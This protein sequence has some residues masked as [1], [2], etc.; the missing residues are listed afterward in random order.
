MGY[1]FDHPSLIELIYDMN[2]QKPVWDEGLKK[3][4]DSSQKLA[5]STHF[6]GKGADN[7]KNYF[8]DVYPQITSMLSGCVYDLRGILSM[9]NEAFQTIEEDQKNTSEAHYEERE[10]TDF[11]DA[12]S[13][14][15]G[16]TQLIDNNTRTALNKVADIASIPYAG[17]EGFENDLRKM[18]KKISELN[19]QIIEME[20]NY[21]GPGIEKVQASIAAVIEFLQDQLAMKDIANYSPEALVQSPSYQKMAK[22]YNEMY[23]EI[24]ANAEKIQHAQEAEGEMLQALY[25]KRVEEAKKAKFWASVVCIVISA[26][27]TVATGGAAAPL[28]MAAT[29]AV[30]GAISAGVGS[31]YDQKIGSPACPGEVSWGRVFTDAAVG[32]AVGAITSYA[33]GAISKGASAVAGKVTSKLGQTMIKAAGGGLKKVVNNGITNVINSGY[34]SIRDGTSFTDNMNA[35]YGGGGWKGY[36]STIGGDFVAGTTSSLVSSASSGLLSKTPLAASGDDSYMERIIKSG[37]EGGVSDIASGISSRYTSTVTKEIIGSAI[38]GEPIDLGAIHEKAKDK[39]LDGD[40][41]LM[42][43]ISGT[44]GGAASGAGN[45]RRERKEK[46]EFEKKQAELEKAKEE[47]KIAKAKEKQAEEKLKEVAAEADDAEKD[48]KKAQKNLAKANE[49][50]EAAEADFD[51]K[52]KQMDKYQEQ[53][54]EFAQKKNSPKLDKETGE[55]LDCAERAE[56]EGFEGI[57]KTENGGPEFKDSEYIYVNENGE[58]AVVKIKI[59]T[60]GNEGSDRR[61]DYKNTYDALVEQ[62]VL[63][64]ENSEYKNGGIYVDGKRYTVQHMD[65]YDVRSGESTVELVERDA[66]ESTYPHGG[67]VSQSKQAHEAGCNDQTRQEYEQS[68]SDM[69]DAQR[70]ARSAQKQETQAQQNYNEAKDKY[71]NSQEDYKSAK[72]ERTEKT[73]E[74]KEAQN[75]YD[76]AKKQADQTEEN[77]QSNVDKGRG[78]TKD[79]KT[80]TKNTRDI[81]KSSKE[82]EKDSAGTSSPPP[83]NMQL[84]TSY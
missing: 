63:S 60:T 78:L 62:G 11:A 77:R 76:E 59:T 64:P 51:E 20:A 26:A 82:E 13:Y 17:T 16:T 27:V 84:Q 56:K 4:G 46:A 66:H 57:T 75:G 40:E 5:N 34:E 49:K 2:K 15:P 71:S 45:L 47:E 81:G 14:H 29:G 80:N 25:E 24:E 55:Y 68:R 30:T 48:L 44:V 38:D 74:R 28:V 70:D 43:A 1:V 21:S 61:Q 79:T 54:D 50:K 3:M 41:I 23:D 19:T 8:A 7:M 83:R 12:L 35:K 10:M 53:V 36:L 39:A 32:G 72:S 52:D 6:S 58:K 9:Y 42:D 69:K 31:Y 18:I 37:V 73:A 65:D 67:S 33:G 22:T